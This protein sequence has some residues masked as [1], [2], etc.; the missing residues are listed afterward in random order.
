[1]VTSSLSDYSLD[2]SAQFKQSIVAHGGTLSVDVDTY[3]S[4]TGKQNLLKAIDAIKAKANNLHGV[5]FTGG[6]REAILFAQE[7]RRAG[8]NQPIL[9]GEDLFTTEYLSAGDAVVGS[10]LYTTFSSHHESPKAL[11]FKLDYGEDNPNRFAALAYDSFMLIAQAIEIAGSTR[12]S[13]VRDAII[14]MKEFEGA[15]GKIS[16]TPN[17]T[18]IKDA[19]IYSIKKSRDGEQFV[20]LR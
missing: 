2:L 15:T 1:M 10:L 17:G 19:F 12:S 8:L 20:L 14:A 5:I 4:Y 9:G 11:E 7:M 3:D 18:P 6:S 16:F 13:R